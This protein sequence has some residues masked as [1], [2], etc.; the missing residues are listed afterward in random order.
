MEKHFWCPNGEPIFPYSLY[1]GQ[2]VD[3]SRLVIV[4]QKSDEPASTFLSN[5]PKHGPDYFR[6]MIPTFVCTYKTVTVYSYFST[7]LSISV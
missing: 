3:V 6:L 5:P 4:Y 7:V 2:T 1:T